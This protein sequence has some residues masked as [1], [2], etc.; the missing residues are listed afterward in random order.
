MTPQ[1]LKETKEI[2]QEL[3]E[4]SYNKLDVSSGKMCYNAPAI[5]SF[6]RD[7]K[8]ALQTALKAIEQVEEAGKDYKDMRMFQD[9][10]INADQERI[11]L[12]DRV[13]EL[14][15]MQYGKSPVI[16]A[17]PFVKEI[18]KLEAENKRLRK[19]LP[20]EEPKEV[21]EG[22]LVEPM[23]RMEIDFSYTNL[24]RERVVEYAFLPSGRIVAMTKEESFWFEADGTSPKGSYLTRCPKVFTEFDQRREKKEGAKR[25][26]Q[27]GWS[28]D[29][30][31]PNRLG[32]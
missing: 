19:G 29:P 26:P 30:K 27:C 12:K 32:T 24:P 1:E 10:Y 22:K 6:V 23:V 2:L 20:K 14:E 16:V 28:F 9:K 11:A 18:K 15:K 17:I 4:N 31:Y 8:V 7:Y 3:E 21:L 25:C 5:F 13:K